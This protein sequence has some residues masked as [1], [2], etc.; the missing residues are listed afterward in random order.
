M[1]SLPSGCD[2]MARLN[3][4]LNQKSRIVGNSHN[5]VTLGLKWILYDVYKMHI[6]KQHHHKFW[7]NSRESLFY[8]WG[9]VE[10]FAFCCSQ[11]TVYYERQRPMQN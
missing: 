2:L 9:L 5:K 7:W 4:D 8:L 11:D 6:N 1:S 10:Y 3:Y